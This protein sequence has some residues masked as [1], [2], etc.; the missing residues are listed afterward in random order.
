VY[1]NKICVRSHPSLIRPH[2]SVSSLP[3]PPQLQE[4]MGM[5]LGHI[6][7]DDVRPPPPIPPPAL[8]S[9]W[10][11]PTPLLPLFHHF[12]TSTTKYHPSTEGGNQRSIH[13][14]CLHAHT[15]RQTEGPC[16]FPPY[17]PSPL[18][19]PLS[20]FTTSQS[21]NQLLSKSPAIC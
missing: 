9:H 1:L 12:P 11:Y 2:A 7:M 8:T 21:R 4:I 5:L 20:Y 10:S 6:A 3:L 13:M 16:P 18:A 17:F 15:V 19:P 14:G